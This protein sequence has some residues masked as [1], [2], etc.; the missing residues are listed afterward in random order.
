MPAFAKWTAR[1]DRAIQSL[2][3]STS[4]RQAAERAGLHERTLRRWLADPLF[5]DRLAVAQRESHDAAL[6]ELRGLGR[7]AVAAMRRCLVC[8]RFLRTVG[9]PW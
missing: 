1:H 8:D 5:A 4:I 6:G 2:L 7:Q 9:D 3:T